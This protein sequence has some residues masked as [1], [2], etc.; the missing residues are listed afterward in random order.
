MREEI[1]KPLRNLLYY[2]T[3]NC[4]FYIVVFFN[5]RVFKNKIVTKKLK[6]RKFFGVFFFNHEKYF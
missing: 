2:Q 4:I 6:R 1:S 3:N 5:F